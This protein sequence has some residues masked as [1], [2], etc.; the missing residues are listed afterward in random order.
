VSSSGKPV[1]SLPTPADWPLSRIP[2]ISAADQSSLKKLGIESTQHLLDRCS[3]AAQKQV[4]S[5]HLKIPLRFIHKW[6]ALADLAQI[7][8]VGPEACGL[9]LHAG[10]VS[11]QQLAQG[12]PQALHRN[13]CRLQVRSI[14]QRGSQ[15][16][17]AQVAEWIRQAQQRTQ[18]DP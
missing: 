1:E 7:P 17:F 14:G 6:V 3:T 4:L 16:S 8:S 18:V 12:S 9:L 5:A 15:L 10:I 13:L 2:G 11:V